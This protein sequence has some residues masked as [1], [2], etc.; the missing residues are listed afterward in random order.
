MIRF[1]ICVPVFNV[2][3][4]LPQCLASIDAQSYKNYEVILVN[5]GS[6]DKSGDLCR[7][8]AEAHAD[9]VTLVEQGNHGLLFARRAA[10]KAAS[11]DY[12]LCLDSDDALSPRTLDCLAELIERSDSDVVVFQSSTSSALDAPYFDFSGLLKYA[13]TSGRVPVSKARE[14]LATSHELNAMWNKAIRRECVGVND[15]YGDYEGLQYGE[16]LFQMV[17]ILDRARTILVADEILYY[18]RLNPE[19][20]SHRVN[21]N[22]LKDIATVRARLV[23]YASR[24]DDGLLPVVFSNNCIEVL[25]YC[26]M[27]ANRL[28]SREAV[29]AIRDAVS[30]EF[31]ATSLALANLSAIPLWKKTPLR[32]LHAKAWR[33]FIFYTRVLFGALKACGSDKGMRYC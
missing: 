6:T 28:S 7:C 25:A 16:D 19:S 9:N 5:D 27:C 4:Y 1:S 8:Y 26:F 13:D 33:P 3:E 20:I 23:D 17:P 18:Y 12:I 11:G 21:P 15:D 14:I 24:W 2:E 22:R 29:E 32:L 31:F 10:M 30:G